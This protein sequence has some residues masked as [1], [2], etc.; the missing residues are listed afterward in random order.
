MGNSGI[1]L[2]I[3]ATPNLGEVDSPSRMIPDNIRS[4][5]SKKNKRSNTA[6]RNSRNVSSMEPTIF[7]QVKLIE[8]ESTQ[9]SE[10]KLIAH[11]HA[12]KVLF[13]IE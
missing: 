12:D 6:H 7:P 10:R 3:N 13:Q 4:A 1:N 9:I 2:R 8:T 11:T 5:L